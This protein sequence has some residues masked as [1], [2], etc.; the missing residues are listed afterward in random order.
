MNIRR[1]AIAAVALALGAGTG[2]AGIPVTYDFVE[3][4]SAPHPGAIGATITRP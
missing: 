3:G 4:P 2:R 1:I